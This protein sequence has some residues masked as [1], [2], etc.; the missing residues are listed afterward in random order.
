M[1]LDKCARPQVSTLINVEFSTLPVWHT[2]LRG[3]TI[4]VNDG[5][6]SHIWQRMRTN[7]VL[8]GWSNDLS[9]YVGMRSCR[10]RSCCYDLC[11]ENVVEAKLLASVHKL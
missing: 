8:D 1:P 3:N 9:I 4:L 11:S 5:K 7:I 10:E 2:S 6:H